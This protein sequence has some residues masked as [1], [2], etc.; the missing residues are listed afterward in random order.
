M[1]A[2]EALNADISPEIEDLLADR[3]LEAIGKGQGQDHG[4]DADHRCADG[5]SDDKTGKRPLAVESDPPGYK[6]CYVQA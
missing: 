4:R 5:Q 3:I 6:G 2:R 1:V